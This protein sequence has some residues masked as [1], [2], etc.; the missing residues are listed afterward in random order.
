MQI[1]AG[2]DL[3]LDAAFTPPGGAAA[4]CGRVHAFTKSEGHDPV[5]FGHRE[6]PRAARA[7]GRGAGSLPDAGTG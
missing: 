6:L 1:G 7:V 3:L 2:L 5:T 4:G